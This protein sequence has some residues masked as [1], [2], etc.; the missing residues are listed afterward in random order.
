MENEI[1]PGFCSAADI[2]FSI[3]IWGVMAQRGSAFVTVQPAARAG[4]ILPFFST[5]IRPEPFSET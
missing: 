2:H 5:R 1:G 4:S 3:G